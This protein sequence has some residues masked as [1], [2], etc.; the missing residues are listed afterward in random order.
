MEL[1]GIGL[2]ST[3]IALIIHYSGASSIYTKPSLSSPSVALLR[4]TLTPCF[5]TK[6]FC[7]LE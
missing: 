1:E 2:L 4:L 7:N 3:G 5:V 6:I